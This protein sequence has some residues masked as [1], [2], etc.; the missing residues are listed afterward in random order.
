MANKNL[1][2]LADVAIGL[3]KRE[4]S[5]TVEYPGYLTVSDNEATMDWGTANEF[6]GGDNAND[7]K[8][9]ILYTH[10]TKIPSTSTDVEAIVTAIESHMR[11]K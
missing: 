6:W 10:E 4:F 2:V 5:V 3:R 1:A 8:A 11:G 9:Q 7:E